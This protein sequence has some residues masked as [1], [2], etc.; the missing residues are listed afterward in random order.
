MKQRRSIPRLMVAGISSGSGKTTCMVALC[1]AL[2]RRGLRVAVFK[3]GP[4]YLDPTYHAR[5]AKTQS[6]TLDAWMMGRE[7]VLSTFDSATS[8][9]DIALIEGVM[10]LFDGIGPASD[11]GS[12]A[13]LA[14]W[15][16]V[17]VLLVVDVAGMARTLAAIVHGC[18]SFDPE[19]SFAGVLCNRVG[20]RSHLELLRSAISAPSVLGALPR[21]PAL[22]FAERHLGLRTADHGAL[23]EEQ[24]DLWADRLEQWCDLE[25]VLAAAREDPS[26]AVPNPASRPQQRTSVSRCRMGMPTTRPS[27][28]TTKRTFVFSAKPGRCWFPSLRSATVRSCRLTAFTSAAVI[29]R[30][31]RKRSPRTPRCETPSAPLPRLVAPCM[32]SAATLCISARAFAC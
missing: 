29:P 1:R 31:T 21:E 23:T 14:K 20:S 7:A 26:L 27:T 5:A 11:E 15:L 9:A 13:Q 19:L 16:Q 30:C 6:H 18:T 17:P 2:A 25:H 3:T 24:L 10:G 12:T 28:S 4:D 8:D 32:R 22:K